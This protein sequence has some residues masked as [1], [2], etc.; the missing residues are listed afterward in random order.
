MKKYNSEKDLGVDFVRFLRDNGFETWQEV[1]LGETGMGTPTA[2]I[3]A[4]KEGEFYLFELKTKISDTLLEQVV[5][6][7]HF[8]NHAYA[9]IPELPRRKIARHNTTHLNRISDVKKYYIERRGIGLIL[10]KPDTPEN[11]FTGLEKFQR[12]E[13]QK[14]S[15]DCWQ[16]QTYL[17]IE[18]QLS[19]AGSKFGEKITP[20]KLSIK[21]MI[22]FLNESQA[23]RITI[24]KKSMWVALDLH[25][26]SYS[27][28]CGSLR[29]FNHLEGIKIINTLL[30]E[31]K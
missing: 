30:E 4:K 29:K 9:V 12:I 1:V 19:E 21:K 3:V 10:F 22:D 14:K 16:L 18:Q 24:T 2:D 8:F 5:N 13:P 15:K 27:S 20:F 23:K 6:R 28:M 7:K 11:I 26:A 31:M 25:W 17:K